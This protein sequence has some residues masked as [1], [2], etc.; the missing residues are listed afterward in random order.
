MTRTSNPDAI[1]EV[2]TTQLVAQRIHRTPQ[3]FRKLISNGKLRSVELCDG[4]R[5]LV[6]AESLASLLG[7]QVQEPSEASL[8]REAE[9]AL[10]RGGFPPILGDGT[11]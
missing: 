1:P 11:L 3:Y 4:G 8:P 10:S 2:L 9:L 5:H 6:Y 7:I